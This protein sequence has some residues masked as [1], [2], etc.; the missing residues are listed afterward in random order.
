MAL[1]ELGIPTTA[2]ALIA[3]VKTLTNVYL[4]DVLRDERLAVSG[5]KAA[6]QDR[7]L[8]RK[9]LDQVCTTLRSFPLHRY[10]EH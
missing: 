3:K 10:C 8:K 9:S 6:M 5:P 4:K 2:P 7:I 1:G